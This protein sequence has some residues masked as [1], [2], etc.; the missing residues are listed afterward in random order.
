MS[1]QKSWREL[2]YGPPKKKRKRKPKAR[3][4][5]ITDPV[6]WVSRPL[7]RRGGKFRRRGPDGLKVRRKGNLFRRAGPDIISAER[8]D[9][10][11]PRDPPRK[12]TYED[13]GEYKGMRMQRDR[14]GNYDGSDA[15]VK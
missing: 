3:R 1:L 12:P 6:R 15:F 11:T 9:V 7:V 4:P 8:L 10:R 13:I 14:R 2:V 5:G